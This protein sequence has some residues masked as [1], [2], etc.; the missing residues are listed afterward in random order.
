MEIIGVHDIPTMT[1]PISQNHSEGVTPTDPRQPRTP[2][3]CR[4]QY[5]PRRKPSCNVFFFQAEDGI[6]YIGVTG[7]QTCAL[8]IW[9]LQ[10]SYDLGSFSLSVDRVQRDPFAPP[11]LIRV[12][13]KENRFDPGL[14]EGPVRRVAFE[15]FLT[16]AVDTAIR[17]VVRG[18]KGSG[19]SGRV[20]VQR[21]SQVVLPRTSMVVADGYVEARMAVGLPARGRSVDARAARTMLLEELPEVVRRGLFPGG[22]DL[23]LAR[24]HVETVEDA[25]QLRRRLPDL[26]I[27]A[28]VADGSVLPRESGASD[29]PLR[30]GAVPFAS[31]EELRVSVKLPN[32]GEV[33]GMGVPE[34]VTLVAGGGFHGK[35]T[36]LAALSW[37]VYDHVS[38]TV[39]NT[40]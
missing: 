4:W 21:P 3:R 25:D 8:P 12:R 26:G 33:S 31:P 32:R 5:L 38:G 23:D 36:L 19:G 20:E 13:T 9:D 24:L 1:L 27:V 39:E 40:S 22:M 15:D 17:K 2:R 7:V 30:E 16:R 28:F 18:N 35:S 34:G 29:R 14:F 10:G 6:R 11:S 37:G